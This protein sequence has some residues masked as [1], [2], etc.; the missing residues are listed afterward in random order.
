[1]TIYFFDH[2][3]ALKATRFI[4]IV[5][6][7]LLFQESNAQYFNFN[8]Q[9][10][11]SSNGLPG[12]EVES[13]YQDSR[14]YIWIGTRFGLSMFDG[15][16]FRNF[17]HDPN[18]N[19][20]IGGSRVFSI[21]EDKKGG[22][23]VATENFG[24]SKIDL[25]TYKIRNYPIPAAQQL[26]DRYI[27]TLFIDEKGLIWIGTQTGV[28]Y[29]D[30]VSGSY[31]KRPIQAP[32]V[33]Q[34]II[35]F[36]KDDNQ[37]LWAF[38]YT[39]HIFYKRPNENV[40]NY[41]DQP[42]DVAYV[43]KVIKRAQGDLLISTSEGIFNLLS[44]PDPA[45]SVL[46]RFSSVNIVDPISDLAIDR[47]GILWIANKVKGVQLYYEGS[48]KLQNLNVSSLSP[49]E[50]GIADWKDLMVDRQGG[51]WLGGD[52]GL[53]HYNSDYNQFNV[54]KAI[55]KFVDQFSFGKYVGVSSH[56]NDIITVSSKGISIFDRKEHDFKS[57]KFE[58]GLENKSTL[59]NGIVQVD[60]MT[61][62][63][64]TSRGI[65]E[66]QNEGNDYLLR[67]PSLFKYHP[68]LG[69]KPVYGIS[70]TPEGK[71][72]FAT[73]ENGLLLFDKK[74][75]E[76][77]G[78][79]QLGT[80]D[81]KR[82]I[83]HLDFV[84]SSAEG[85]VA[86]G[87]HRGF[88]IKLHDQKEF[89]HIDQM[90]GPSYDFSKLSV[91]DMEYKDGYLW[92]ASESDGL[93]RFDFKQ[94]QIKVYTMGD[95]LVSNSI[96]SIHGI[97]NEKMVIGTN[98]GMSIMHIP[99]ETFI[100]F[101]KK[102]GLPAEEFEIAVNHAIDNREIF[103]A[104]TKGVVSFFENHLKQSLIRPKLQLY[105][106]VRNGNYLSDS[107]VDAIRKS[108]K[109]KLKS[110]ESLNFQF[111]TLNYSN[112]NDFNLRFKM[113]DKADWQTSPSSES[114]SLFNLEPGVYKIVVQLIGKRSGIMSNQVSM[115][116]EV[117]PNFFKTRL[118]RFILLLLILLFLYF[119]VS[120]FFE[121]RLA[122][123]KMELEKKQLLEQE[124]V[125]IAMD[126]HDDIGGN[127]SA[128][129]L[130]TN[131]LKEKT[132]ST[133]DWKL[134][135]K[136]GEAS[137][138]MVQDMNEIVWALNVSNDSLISLLSYIRQYL[139]TRLSAAGILLE[140]SEPIAYPDMFVSGRVR[141]NVFMI[142][143]EIINNAIKYAGTKKIDIK[144]VLD[145]HL[146]IT[147]FDNGK[148]MPEEL[149]NQT[150]KGGGNGINNIKKRASMMNAIVTF[151]NEKGL[152]V[153]LDLPLDQFLK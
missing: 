89:Q 101:L 53:Y 11:T 148:G 7:L 74:T 136:I 105:S 9:N 78:Y 111:S 93:L 137:E 14:G 143:K 19:A 84:T 10:Y 94:K 42:L 31:I 150:I 114:L 151:K 116:L 83:N 57:L 77:K 1:M 76:T 20:S 64:P 97:G 147:I 126:L 34:E 38:G 102:D 95:G 118:F 132:G 87:H 117:M 100:T 109:F 73:P 142:V 104:T 106:I 88:A 70:V 5:V 30:P 41:L 79:L 123:Q 29:F 81:Y 37:V 131:I 98:K 149:T 90:I 146:K 28:S 71:I 15:T 125:R 60:A 32:K 145:Q 52:F 103:M 66:L 59:H 50:P 21:Q 22:L 128:L 129:A 40:F 67:R 138:K 96:T 44:S 134:I 119:P 135:D 18:D 75:N 26:E 121:K 2:T 17:L 46:K 152:T 122:V 144:V 130:M 108:P 68:I 113:N 92:V 49:L 91:Y 33:N 65:L 85:D 25:K 36:V 43:S 61:W 127:L 23:W 86:V 58:K 63:I 35:A 110:N 139:S 39:G 12:N 48:A 47:N 124:R 120:N 62:W 8:F 80:G 115:E 141:R 24:I 45:Q 4:C 72:W 153:L 51:V 99:S 3:K 27:N 107:I 16:H 133:A 13:L 55:S 82:T 69:K 54:Y 56:K 112:D 6:F 140:I